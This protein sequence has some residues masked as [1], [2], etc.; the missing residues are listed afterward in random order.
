MAS[1]GLEQLNASYEDLTRQLQKTVLEKD[2]LAEALVATNRKLHLSATRDPL[3][4]RPV[5][6][7]FVT[8]KP[9]IS[10]SP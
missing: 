4:K 5:G 8:I 6:K 3:T 9:E 7:A 1:Q 10:S 2:R